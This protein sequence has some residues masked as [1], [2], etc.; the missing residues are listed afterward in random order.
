MLRSKR[1]QAFEQISQVKT[2]V[3]LTAPRQR[4]TVEGEV[5]GL[6]LGRLRGAND[7]MSAPNGGNEGI[8]ISDQLVSDQ[9]VSDRRP[10]GTRAP[11]APVP[12]CLGA[13]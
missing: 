8:V 9:L 6:S 11:D 1:G 10:V 5:Q 4:P 12:Q 2:G 3:R 7:S 13:P